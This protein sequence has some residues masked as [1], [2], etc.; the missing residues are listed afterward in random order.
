M[1][2]KSPQNGGKNIFNSL[3]IIT[4]S[5]FFV[6]ILEIRPVKIHVI[7]FLGLVNGHIAFKPLYK[8]VR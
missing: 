8:L 2:P 1:Y 4:Q 3:K 6:I 7:F 5:K